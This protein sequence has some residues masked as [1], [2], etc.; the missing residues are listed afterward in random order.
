MVSTTVTVD[1][2]EIIDTD[3]EGF[4]D[5]I[6]ERA[7]DPLGMDVSYNVVGVE[8]S[9]TLIVRVHYIE[10]ESDDDEGW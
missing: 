10:S 2:D 8:D 1:L 5:L 3:L 7:G 9:S 6:L 4:I